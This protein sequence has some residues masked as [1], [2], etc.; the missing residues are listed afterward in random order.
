VRSNGSG[1]HFRG[2][3]PAAGQTSVQGK[4]VDTYSPYPANDASHFPSPACH[5][6]MTLCSPC[7]SGIG[8]RGPG[9]TAA[10]HQGGY[11]AGDG[12]PIKQQRL[13]RISGTHYH[14]AAR[15]LE[16]RGAQ[17][18]R[19][20]VW[21]LKIHCTSTPATCRAQLPT[22][23]RVLNGRRQPEYRARSQQSATA[24]RK[25]PPGHVFSIKRT[26]KEAEATFDVARTT[27]STILRR[28]S[29]ACLNDSSASSRPSAKPYFPRTPAQGLERA[30]SRCSS[31]AK[32]RAARSGL[33]KVRVQQ[34]PVA[35]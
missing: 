7:A 24:A 30:I 14:N 8:V 15:N 10:L 19:S 6:I 3:T 20:H 4:T 12:S 22:T 34:F 32:T 27:S 17:R 25:G 11:A 23:T 35:L 33:T 16:Q 5:S 29:S 21:S 1:K 26:G 18:R 2:T 31:T 9:Q 13:S 28:Q